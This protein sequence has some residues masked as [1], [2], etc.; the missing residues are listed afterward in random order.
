MEPYKK[1]SYNGIT[2][3]TGYEVPTTLDR[4]DILSDSV[5]AYLFPEAYKLRVPIEYPKMVCVAGL[6]T[7]IGLVTNASGNCAV[8]VDPWSYTPMWIANYSA[9]NPLTGANGTSWVPSSVRVIN[10]DA[11]IEQ[12][13]VV[14][15]AVNVFL[16]V[17]QN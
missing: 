5:C 4:D 2:F 16:T 10:T 8:Y 7:E 14:S 6:P 17:S 1:A 12:Y 3:H 11:T 13:R 15:T 9:F